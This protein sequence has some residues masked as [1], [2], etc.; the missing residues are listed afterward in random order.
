MW[1]LC[2][3]KTTFLFIDIPI[4]TIFAAI[5]TST[6]LYKHEN[7]FLLAP[8]ISLFSMLILSCGKDDSIPSNEKGDFIKMKING[9]ER[10]LH[11]IKA[12]WSP[13]HTR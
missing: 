3:I 6:N 8:L 4:A 1:S 13:E 5:I 9:V 2:I 7:K 12:N 11:Y 10:V